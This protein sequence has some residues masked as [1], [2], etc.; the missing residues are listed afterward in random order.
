MLVCK[1]W[2]IYWWFEDD[3]PGG[4]FNY[5]RRRIE[6]MIVVR[7]RWFRKRIVFCSIVKRICA[8]VAH[9]CFAFVQCVKYV[10]K[11]SVIEYIQEGLR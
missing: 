8:K 5:G 2:F 7:K 6:E 1:A 4:I 10:I 11:I 9:A 3:F